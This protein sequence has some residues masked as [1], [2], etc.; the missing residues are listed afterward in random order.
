MENI[1]ENC[2]K[3][4]LDTEMIL[5]QKDID[6][7]IKSYPIKIRKQE[8]AFKNENGNFQ[9]KNFNNYCVFFDFSTK[10]CKIYGYHPLG[11]R[12]YPLIYDFQKKVCS[13]D[14]ICPRTHLFY[15]NKKI[16]TKVCENLKNFI[17]IQLKIELT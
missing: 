2:G 12:F 14:K 9:I 6:L 11:C 8:F 5:S 4:C 15:Q 16:L 1:C 3:C 17:E 10:K 7:I 13:F